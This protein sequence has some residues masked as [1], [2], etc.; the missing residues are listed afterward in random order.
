[1]GLKEC[2]QGHKR[3]KRR[4][5]KK[6]EEEEEPRQ[7]H[8]NCDKRR[9]EAEDE[10]KRAKTKPNKNAHNHELWTEN[11]QIPL[12]SSPARCSGAKAGVARCGS[13]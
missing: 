4:S 1:M 3:R 5:K 13:P 12:P 11:R 7:Q 9:R 10:G 2:G 6:E 8:N